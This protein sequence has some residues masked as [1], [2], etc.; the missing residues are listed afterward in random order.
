MIRIQKVTRVLINYLPFILFCSY[1]FIGLL[2]GLIYFIGSI[3]A[4]IKGR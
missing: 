2:I 4:A 3:F 1:S